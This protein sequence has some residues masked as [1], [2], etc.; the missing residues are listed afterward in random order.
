[1]VRVST[2]YMGFRSDKQFLNF[3]AMILFWQDF[4]CKACHC[5]FPTAGNGDYHLHHRNGN[6]KDNWVGNVEVL[7]LPCHQLKHPEKQ[8][9]EMAEASFT[10]QALPDDEHYVSGR[11]R[12]IRHFDQQIWK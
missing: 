3:R 1:M 5:F 6:P 2:R 12:V 10:G 8:L 9:L 11:D 7:C 4:S